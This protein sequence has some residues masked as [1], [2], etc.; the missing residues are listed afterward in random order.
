[1]NCVRRNTGS[2]RANVKSPSRRALLYGLLSFAVAFPAAA[3]ASGLGLVMNWTQAEGKEIGLPASVASLFN[4][5]DPKHD[6]L[7]R[8]EAYESADNSQHYFS[9]GTKKKG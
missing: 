2:T 1:M 5:S 7:C 3:P 4:L 6:W 8:T 9:V